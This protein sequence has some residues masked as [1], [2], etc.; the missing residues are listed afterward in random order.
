MSDGAEAGDPRDGERAFLET[1]RREA[2]ARLD[3]IV[4]ALASVKEGGA[5]RETAE[6]VFLDV[7]TIRGA[8]AMLALDDVR[9]LAH[10]MGSAL[11]R[12]GG[13]IP[14]ELADRLLRGAEALR[15]QVAG[16]RR[17]SAQL[18]AEPDRAAPR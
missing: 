3:R 15:R 11:E 1:F 13:A 12:A 9:T 4:S 6:K 16:D 10:A 14:P 7:H 2:E 5:T 18:P 8:A 17:P